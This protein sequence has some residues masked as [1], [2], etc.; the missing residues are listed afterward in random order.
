VDL[1]SGGDVL[2]G[3]KRALVLVILAGLL[4]LLFVSSPASSVTLKQRLADVQKK[5][6]VLYS[7][8]DA[9]VERYNEA[10]SRLQTVN[11]KIAAN[12]KQLKI[13]VFRLGVARVD[14]QQQVV[15]SYK[16]GGQVD[17]LG[18]IL[19]TQNFDQLVSQFDA[20]QR[21]SRQAS[22][23]VDTVEATKHEI[24]DLHVALAA[25]RESAKKLVADAQQQ[26]AT[27]TSLIGKQREVAKGLEAQIKEQERLAALAAKRAAEAA[28]RAAEAARLA[29]AS[30]PW[31]GGYSPV[32]DPG[33][34]GHPEVVALAQKYLGVPYVWGGA[35]PSGFDCSGLVMYVYAKIGIYLPHGATMQQH[36][37]K[38]VPLGSLQPGDLI[39]FGGPSFSH[40]V[41]IY[42]GGGMMINA[43]HTGAVVSYASYASFGDA[44]IGG[45]F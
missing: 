17:I 39:F 2:N 8:Q 7:Q 29:A 28:A 15:T 10:T 36:M 16:T 45:R 3:S 34:P 11:G 35:S 33:G 44:W 14:L 31:S 5:L 1:Q 41:G 37:S 42:V 43:P 27:V 13:T 4:S 26:K 18:V 23:T 6:S 38:P 22:H 12:E 21:F 40:H 30:N 19:S 24:Q 9:A 32:V 25:D 20:M